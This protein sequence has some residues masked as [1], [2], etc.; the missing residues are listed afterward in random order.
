MSSPEEGGEGKR[1]KLPGGGKRL[2]SR[3]RSNRV[4]K[5]RKGEDLHRGRGKKSQPFFYLPTLK[6]G[7]R[8]VMR[9]KEKRKRG[10]V[11]GCQF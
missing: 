6:G 7:G 11:T 10:K 1:E 9:K 3:S 2:S 5:E 4:G 8:D